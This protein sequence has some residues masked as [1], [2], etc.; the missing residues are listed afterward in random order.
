MQYHSSWK[1]FIP[2]KPTLQLLQIP[3]HPAPPDAVFKLCAV[4]QKSLKS[5]GT[6]ICGAWRK[7]LVSDGYASVFTGECLVWSIS[8][9]PAKAMDVFAHGKVKNFLACFIWLWPS[10]RN[11]AT[12]VIQENKRKAQKHR[13][14]LAI[15]MLARSDS[16]SHS[17]ILPLLGL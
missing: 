6:V 9:V 14:F 4:L 12:G 17:Q 10:I 3:V 2:E 15:S 11:P 1:N 7:V 8:I 13:K 16:R 5:P